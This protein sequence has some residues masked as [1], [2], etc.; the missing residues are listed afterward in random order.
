MKSMRRYFAMHASLVVAKE[1]SMLEGSAKWTWR[2]SILSI[3]SCVNMFF[4]PLILLPLFILSTGPVYILGLRRLQQRGKKGKGKKNCLLSLPW[5][6]IPYVSLWGVQRF[7]Q[8]FFWTKKTVGVNTASHLGEE[9][10][11]EDQREEEGLI[12]HGER[13]KKKKHIM[14]YRNSC[15]FTDFGVVV[16]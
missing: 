5:Q 12:F 9:C 3:K 6:N 16:A 8:A 14:S 1:K 4:S 15:W 2:G 13:V 10:Y 7:C 11:K